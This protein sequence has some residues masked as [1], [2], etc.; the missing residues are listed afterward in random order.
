MTTATTGT[1]ATDRGDDYV[2]RWPQVISGRA[3]LGVE[4]VAEA[5]RRLALV[6]EDAQAG[7]RAA[8][9][10]REAHPAI[11]A[12]AGADAKRVI[13][14]VVNI[15]NE[16]RARRDTHCDFCGLPLSSNGDCQEC[17]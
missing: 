8:L 14:E 1:M 13:Q 12:L 2:S 17:V 9:L 15:A 5:M 3:G 7:L 10:R 6:D 4:H 11:G 16:I